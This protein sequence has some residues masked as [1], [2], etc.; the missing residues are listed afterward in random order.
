M[1][2]DDSNSA[3]SGDFWPE[4]NLPGLCGLREVVANYRARW[5]PSGKALRKD[6]VA[7]LT[8]AVASVP[9][10]MAGGL[11][12]GVNPIYGLYA[13][14]IG[15]L[16]GSV[17]SSTKLMVI[18]NTSAVSL[19]AG[20]SLLGLNAQDHDAA[21]FLMVVLAGVIA[22]AF[23][24]LRLGKFT[25]FVSYSV[26]TG[27]LTG[28]AAVLILSQLP[29]IAG[30]AAEGANRITQTIDLFRNVRRIN[31][32]SLLMALLTLA[33]TIVL[34]RTRVK[35]FSTLLAIAIP[36]GVVAIFGLRDV[37]TV[38]DLGEI[39]RGIPTPSLP[40]FGHFFEIF[41]GAFA[42]ALVVLVQGAGVSQSVPNP[43]GTK[44]K[45]SRD[46]IAQGMGN[47]A[48]GLFRGLPVG[49]SVSTTALNVMSGATTKWGAI[50]SAIWLGLLVIGI[51]GVVT[52]V[53]MPALGA[54]IILAGSHSI[55][56]SD[57]RTVWLAGWLS[58]V[59]AIITF[60]GML[61]LP[62]QIAI[63]L[64]VAVS[65]LLHVSQASTDVWVVQLV[66]TDGHVEER[67]APAELPSNEVTVL[68]VFGN[69]FFAGARKLERL[70]PS[71]ANAHHPVV[72]LRLRQRSLLGATLVDVLSRYAEKLQVVEGRLYLSG[73]S[74]EG[75]AELKDLRKFHLIGPVRMFEA[76]GIR[77][78]ST[79]AAYDDAEAWLV[80]QS[81]EFADSD[82][83]EKR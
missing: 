5:M 83:P 69:V 71:P 63:G 78:Q 39:P 48:S 70:L 22:V 32:D 42:V 64:G 62:M 38:G 76:T 59:A 17:F 50:S 81:H 2:G 40:S 79:E 37:A 53:T 26:M 49:G 65:I 52:Y 16:A 13:N 43:D 33:I 30:Y 66:K 7:G 82:A 80:K 4:I 56:A 23:G 34:Q 1:K 11:L 10:G 8:V 77:Q 28:I 21:L 58:R 75:H 47:I 29:T 27:F 18:Q 73:L 9:E 20:Q 41:S 24:F 25:R 6:S 61:V 67:K 54:V 72:V 74:K 57:L 3:E 44:R 36:S 19:V 51:P 45:L 35:N 60:V 46:F 68:D 55:K 15:P 31:I 12:A 14:I